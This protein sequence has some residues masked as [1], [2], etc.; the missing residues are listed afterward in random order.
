MM[1]F[2]VLIKNLINYGTAFGK[3]LIT[4][5]IIYFV[6]RY[7]I[8]LI[9]TIVS[10]AL[11]RKNIDPAVKSFL[12]SMINISLIVV[13]LIAVLGALGVETTSFAALL[14]SAGVAIGMAL[15]GNLQN[16]AGGIMI[17]IFKPYKVGDFVEYQNVTGTVKEIQIF[18]TIL[19]T[20]DNKTIYVPNSSIS[21]GVLTNYSNQDMRR[22]DF[23]F[24]VEYGT[25][26][27][28][29]KS[30]IMKVIDADK[31]ILKAPAPLVEINELAGSCVNYAVRVWT[32]PTDYWGVYFD[33]NKNIYEG[34]NKAGINFPFPQ[35]TV[36]QLK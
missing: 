33:M 9:N 19:L 29:I 7:V 21:S 31:R 28:V 20:L 12:S 23:T 4:A 16:F 10:K 11:N 26:Y 8:K 22:V 13:L 15:S 17:L 1:K 24:G 6:G 3:N 27:E 5:L 30:E 36:S 2:D 25:E 18:H 35:I 34:F 32:V 14:A